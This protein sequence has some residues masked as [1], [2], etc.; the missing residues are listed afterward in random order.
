MLLW[1]RDRKATQPLCVPRGLSALW[2]KRNGSFLPPSRRRFPWAHPLGPRWAPE[3]PQE[4]DGVVYLSSADALRRYGLRPRA[5]SA[6]EQPH[7]SSH[8]QTYNTQHHRLTRHTGIPCTIFLLFTGWSA[9]WMT[10]RQA[11]IQLPLSFALFC[12]RFAFF[13]AIRTGA[14]LFPPSFFRV[15]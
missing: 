5:S 6:P 7:P 13:F 8:M 11:S 15:T 3:P 2:C 1:G 14:L 4:A 9:G 10:V 12:G